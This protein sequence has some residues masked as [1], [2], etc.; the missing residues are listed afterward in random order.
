MS[1]TRAL[2][3]SSVT[4]K[5]RPPPDGTLPIAQ[6]AENLLFVLDRDAVSGAN[7]VEAHIQILYTG[8]A[9][10]WFVPVD[11]DENGN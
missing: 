11:D 3:A 8:P 4:S 7:T 1:I 5:A 2:A 9:S 10:E 6:A